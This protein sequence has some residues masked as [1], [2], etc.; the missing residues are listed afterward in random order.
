MK[1]PASL[2]DILPTL[3]ELARPPSEAA[4]YAAPIDGRSLLPDLNGHSAPGEVI[5]EYMAEGTI[6]PMVMIRRGPLQV[7]PLPG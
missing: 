1:T 2:L 7:H 4:A 3:T 6:A 5:G